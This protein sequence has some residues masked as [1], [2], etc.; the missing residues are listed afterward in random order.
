LWYASCD[1]QRLSGEIIL[2]S[3]LGLAL[4][5]VGYAVKSIESIS[6]IYVRRFGYEVRT[7]VIHDPLQTALVQFLSLPKDLVYLEFVSPD[8]P[9]SRLIQAVLKGGG[10][11]HLCYIADNLDRATDV[12]A[13]TGMMVISPPQPAIA[14]AGRRICWLLGEDPLPVELVERNCPGDSC[15][16]GSDLSAAQKARAD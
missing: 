6:E 2:E 8:G 16:P 14:F 9:E 1:R 11:N 15:S 12:L 4:H 5:H 10:L 7:P 3:S 13:Q